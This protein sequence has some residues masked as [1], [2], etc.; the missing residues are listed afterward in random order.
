[1]VATNLRNRM[2]RT[3]YIV[4]K[5]KRTV[6]CRITTVNDAED[7]LCKFGLKNYW[8]GDGPVIRTYIGIAKCSPEDEWDEITGKRLAEYRASRKRQI[9]VNN[10]LK[11]EIKRILKAT[12][13]LYDHGLLKHPNKPRGFEQ[14]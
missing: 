3:E 1:M 9:D 4:N 5:E 8:F 11:K 14:K 12:D 7:R 13:A 6:V 2:V 10:T